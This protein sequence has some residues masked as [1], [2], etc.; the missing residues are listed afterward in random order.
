MHDYMEDLSKKFE[1]WYHVLWPDRVVAYRIQDSWEA[2]QSF[3]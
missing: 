2:C 3:D 1:G